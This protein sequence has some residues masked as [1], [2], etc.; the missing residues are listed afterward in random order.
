MT[1]ISWFRRVS[2]CPLRVL[3]YIMIKWCLLINSITLDFTDLCPD[4]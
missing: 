3:F 2:F 4:I 1:G